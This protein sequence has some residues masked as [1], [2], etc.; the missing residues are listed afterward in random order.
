M[1]KTLLD[2]AFCS[3]KCLTAVLL[4]VSADHLEIELELDL[5]YRV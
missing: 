2:S 3:I 4:N 1:F 5:N